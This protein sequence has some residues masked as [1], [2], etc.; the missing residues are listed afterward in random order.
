MSERTSQ[1]VS[2]APPPLLPPPP[3]SNCLI[4]LVWIKEPTSANPVALWQRWGR[5]AEG[6]TDGT[7]TWSPST[8]TATIHPPSLCL[9]RPSLPTQA[10]PNLSGQ[11]GR[12]RKEEEKGRRG[13]SHQL[14]LS[15]PSRSHTHIAECG[16]KKT[17]LGRLSERSSSSRRRG[18]DG[19]AHAE[20]PAANPAYRR[21]NPPTC[22]IISI[23]SPAPSPSLFSF[24]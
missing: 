5:V 9:T 6:G 3:T 13:G 18:G 21:T 20:A 22:W 8:S 23:F 7:D 17:H 16:Q 19:S 4:S 12:G 15:S 11:E 2:I 24:G 10:L 14:S 1:G